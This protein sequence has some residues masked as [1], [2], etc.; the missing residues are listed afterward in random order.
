MRQ[1]E[2]AVLIPTI[3][4]RKEYLVKCV[5]SIADSDYGAISL[6]LIDGKH[7]YVATVNNALANINA[8]AVLLGND[9][10]EYYPDCISRAMGAM[11]RNF[12][13]LNGMV[14]IRQEHGSTEYGVSLIGK[15]LIRH[16]P[17]NAIMCPD[18]VNYF[19]DQE[20]WEYTKKI[21]KFYFCK[22]AVVIHHMPKDETRKIMRTSWDKDE[23]MWRER[24]ELGYL[25]GADFR[26][27]Y[28]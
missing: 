7:K 6:Y 26:R 28:Q 27:I 4:K 15:N 9:D 14:G 19:N 11:T 20:L 3:W 10:Q 8:D 21:S 13:S 24:Q 17:G 1:L 16:F 18:Y 2:V 25:W 23:T 12:P 5:K 22:Q